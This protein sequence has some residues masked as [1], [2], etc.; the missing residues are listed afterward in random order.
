MD[1]NRNREYDL[2]RLGKFG[3]K[4]KYFEIIFKN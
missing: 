4:Y 3:D 1:I 2:G